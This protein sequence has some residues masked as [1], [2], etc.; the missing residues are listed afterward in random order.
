MLPA[1][2][3]ATPDRPGSAAALLGRAMSP[4]HFPIGPDGLLGQWTFDAIDT[5]R[6]PV[7]PCTVTAAEV[8]HKGGR[9]FGYRIDCDGQSLA[10]LPDHHPAVDA[11]PGLELA[12]DV[13]VLCHGVMFADSERTTAH[14]CGHATLSETHT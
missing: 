11:R 7:G 5:G 2:D 6:F 3:R 4:P 9:T 1:Q 14:S 10:Y 13:D 12:R 8:P